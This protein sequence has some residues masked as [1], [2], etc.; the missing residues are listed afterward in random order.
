MNKGGQVPA[1]TSARAAAVMRGNRRR[2]TSP[3]LSLRRVLHA[4][5]LRF[6]VDLAVLAGSRRVR[7][8]VVFPRRRVAVFVDGCFWH[9]CP[10][11]FVRAKSHSDYWDA[12]L[13]HNA[14][15]DR[16]D[17]QALQLQGWTVIRVWSH[18]DP[19][20]AADRVQQSVGKAMA[21]G[22]GR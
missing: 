8:D 9:G 21:A 10:E 7:P 2:D 14:A 5:G 4:R 13:A 17:E 19:A 15:R 11:H 20:L 22:G 6:R 12:K 16:S 3:E 1:P 18:E